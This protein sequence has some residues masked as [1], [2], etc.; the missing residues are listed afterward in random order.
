[1]FLNIFS[2]LTT[3]KS[4]WLSTIYPK[5]YSKEQALFLLKEIALQL[6]FVIVFA[7]VYYLLYH[8]SRNWYT[9]EYWTTWFMPA[10]WQLGC[11]LLI[12]Y[13]YWFTLFMG[14]TF[15]N[16]VVTINY[17]NNLDISLYAIIKHSPLKIVIALTVFWFREK[18]KGKF[19]TD[20]K[21]VV[22]FLSCASLL[23][24][25]IGFMLT[26][27]S[28]FYANIPEDKKFE[29]LLSFFIGGLIGN[30]LVASPLLALQQIWLERLDIDWGKVFG[31]ISLL[32]LLVSCTFYFYYLQPH[33]LY[34]L[35]VL[36]F[37]PI[38]WFSAQYGWVGGWIS[39]L[40][41]MILIA[42]TVYDLPD[43]TLVIESQFYVVAIGISGLLFGAL[44]NE[45]KQLH[46]RLIKNNDE[47]TLS[48]NK[49]K[50]LSSKLI[51]IQEEE[52]KQLSHE[53]HDDVGQN[54]TALKVELKVLEHELRNTSFDK[55]HD[56]INV[57]ADRIYDSVYRVMNWLRPR[58]LDDLGLKESLSGQYFFERLQKANIIYHCELQG[59]VDELNDKQSILIF[60]IVQE[61]INN[62][63][64]HS[65]A[66]NFYLS[67]TVKSSRIDIVILDDGVGLTNEASASK[68]G[69]YGLMGIEERVVSVDGSFD[70]KTEQGRFLLNVTLPVSV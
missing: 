1:M 43:T 4:S 2:S 25:L 55:S 24:L 42:L 14:A 51:H 26:F 30:L 63:I 29:I 65:K 68:Q 3:G 48:L 17:G 39:S 15:T 67:L 7:S 21:G 32:T 33:T 59:E 6:L 31:G 56:R 35:R 53:L 22:A 12:P 10:G 20:F 70:I 23:Q 61:C 64:R 38:I 28:H 60:R 45:Q 44:A 49:N 69:G 54:I 16:W 19:L 41:T 46:K 57:A 58:V 47:L 52:R 62:A 40:I 66:N 11:L 9:H 13:R 5:S 50:S 27:T 34:L 36:A 37:I 8:F 18:F